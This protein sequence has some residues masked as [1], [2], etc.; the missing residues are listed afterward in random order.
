MIRTSATASPR[1]DLRTAYYEFLR[2]PTI[3]FVGDLVLPITEVSTRTARYFS[4]GRKEWFRNISDVKRARKGTVSRSEM[5]PASD[6]LTLLE[7]THEEPIDDLD[8]DDFSESLPLAEVAAVRTARIIETQTEIDAASVVFNDTDFP[9]SGSTGATVGTA[10]TSASAT[11]ITDLVT[12]IG[13]FLEAWGIMPNAVI[14]NMRTYMYACQTTEVKNRFLAGSTAA[15]MSPAVIP[16]EMFAGMLNI[17]GLTLYL[18]FG[19]TDSANAN[20]STFTAS[21]IWATNRVM[22]TRVGT[23]M[24]LQTPQIGR[25]FCL[26]DQALVKMEEYRDE[27]IKCDVIRATR[28]LVRKRMINPVGYMLRGTT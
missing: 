26:A 17:P 15:A 2:D 13:V 25:T 27:G 9:A 24:D 14:M 28:E 19:I 7:Y 20:S 16:S 4:V 12:G 3:G 8:R 23:S 1:D 18:P 21:Q 10:W 5:T 11:P 22:I 6:T